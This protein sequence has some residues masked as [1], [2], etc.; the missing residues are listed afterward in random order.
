MPGWAF[1]LRGPRVL[2]KAALTICA[3]LFLVFVLW[4]GYPA[5][6]VAFGLLL[7]VHVM[8]ANYLLEPGLASARFGY[9][10]IFCLCC[11]L[12]ISV[13]VYLPARNL[14]EHHWLVPLRVNEQVVVVDRTASARVVRRG[15][16]IAYS[17]DSDAAAGVVVQAGYGLSP[18]LAMPGDHV[19]FTT[20]SF[21][22]NGLA[23][24]RHASMP[25]GGEFVIPEKRWLVWPDI[26][27]LGH[28]HVNE[29]QITTML[30]EIAIISEDRFAGKPFKRWFWR[31]QHVS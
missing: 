30:L 1:K 31:R 15:D 14:I 28:G 23:Q 7:S 9:R 27:M 8:G 3:L 16:W 10:I 5:S 12:I 2:G 29:S 20:N 26:A 17:I 6:N 21:E 22:V 13:L 18:V 19:R 24:D 11:C 4:L 25:Q